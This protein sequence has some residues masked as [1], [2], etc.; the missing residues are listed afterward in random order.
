[1]CSHIVDIIPIFHRRQHNVVW[2]ISP[3]LFRCPSHQMGWV[4]ALLH[5]I[6]FRYGDRRAHSVSHHDPIIKPRH[7]IDIVVAEKK[8]FEPV[9]CLV[10]EGGVVGNKLVLQVIGEPQSRE[11]AC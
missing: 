8:L 10:L 2:I 7:V 1:M 6:E 4:F 5:L 9:D 11:I 3:N